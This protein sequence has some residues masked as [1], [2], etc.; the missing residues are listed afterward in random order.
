ML[1]HY[2]LPQEG[3]L[4]FPSCLVFLCFNLQVFVF[5]KTYTG[6]FLKDTQ[7]HA[8]PG[9]TEISLKIQLLPEISLS[10]NRFKRH[11]LAEQNQ[12]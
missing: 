9:M 10:N 4:S 2:G 3:T 12:K 6:T 5:N 11:G 7:L 8:K 1:G